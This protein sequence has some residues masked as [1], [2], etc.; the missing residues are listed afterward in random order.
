MGGETTYAPGD[1]VTILAIVGLCFVKQPRQ[2]FRDPTHFVS[3]PR[4]NA[5]A[6]FHELPQNR[7][8]MT[9]SG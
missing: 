6:P 1:P 2:L 8:K 5:F 3:D 7:S 4:R 9:I